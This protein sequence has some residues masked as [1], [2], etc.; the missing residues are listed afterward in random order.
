MLMLPSVAAA[1]VAEA[2]SA[3]R[4]RHANRFVSI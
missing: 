4:R 1:L 3:V 2:A